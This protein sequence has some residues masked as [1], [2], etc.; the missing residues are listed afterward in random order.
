MSRT[1]IIPVI[2]NFFNITSLSVLL[3]SDKKL[4]R[5]TLDQVHLQTQEGTQVLPRT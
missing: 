4:H 3:L 2:W 1:K 5:S